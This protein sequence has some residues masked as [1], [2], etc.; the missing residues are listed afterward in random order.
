[1]GMYRELGRDARRKS[2]RLEVEAS[3]NRH[4]FV[5][6]TPREGKE[7][8]AILRAADFQAFMYG[9]SESPEGR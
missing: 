3:T 5:R 1:M 6:W 7:R 2:R 4:F 9:Y 8:E